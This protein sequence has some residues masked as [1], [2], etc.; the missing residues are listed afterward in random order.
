MICEQNHGCDPIP[1]TPVMTRA[2]QKTD[3]RCAPVTL[4]EEE[5]TALEALSAASG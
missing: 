4:T 5:Q 3:P 2:I 1:L